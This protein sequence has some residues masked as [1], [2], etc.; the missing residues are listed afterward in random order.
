MNRGARVR[1]DRIAAG[2]MR[3]LSLASALLVVFIVLALAW[4]SAPILSRRPLGSLLGSSAWQPLR[5]DFGFLP[6]LMGTVWVTGTAL[7]LAVPFALLTAIYLVE[8]AHPAVRR[9]VSP[10]IDLLAGIPSVVY[11][12]WGVLAVV[13]L[14]RDRL[15]PLFGASSTGYSVLAGG[16]VLAVMILPV[17]LHVAAEVFGSVPAGMREASLALGATRWQTVTRVVLRKAL[18]GVI[19]AVVL[20]VSRAFGETMAVLMVAGN[21]ASVP[22]SVFDPAYPLPALIANNYGEMMSVPL[23]D[24]A[25]MFAALVLLGVVVAFNAVS[26]CVLLRVERGMH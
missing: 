8:Y 11:G 19:A 22:R 9:W 18:P 4:K 24:S 17:I 15:A 16:A 14:V 13:P 21:V 12:I 5:G 3:L 1:A 10:L 25:L 7:V 26:R 20:G 6:F 23:Y 2:G